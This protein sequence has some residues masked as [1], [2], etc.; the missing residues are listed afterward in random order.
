[1][2][3]IKITQAIDSNGNVIFANNYNPKT[4]TL[5]LTCP[6]PKCTA[7]I[8]HVSGYKRESYG[9]Q[10]YIADF[11]DSR[12]GLIIILNV[13]SSHQDKIVYL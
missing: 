2:S 4:V 13:N 11:F 12:E 1:M 8:K 6:D 9:Q 5:P 3:G 10:Q 7:Q